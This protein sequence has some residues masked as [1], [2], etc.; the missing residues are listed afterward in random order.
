[1]YDS[2]YMPSMQHRSVHVFTAVTS[3]VTLHF[4]PR[5][6]LARLLLSSVGGVDLAGVVLEGSCRAV[7]GGNGTRGVRGEAAGGARALGREP[8]TCER[9]S[10]I[11]GGYRPLT[12]PRVILQFDFGDPEVRTSSL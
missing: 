1:M 10:C 2:Q 8:Y 7:A 5:P 12:E 3:S 4:L 9:L 6:R 11:R